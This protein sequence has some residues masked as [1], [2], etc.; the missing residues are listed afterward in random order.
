MRNVVRRSSHLLMVG[1]GP[2]PKHCSFAAVDCGPSTMKVVVVLI[3]F[4]V[5][6]TAASELDNFEAQHPIQGMQ[7][8]NNH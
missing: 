6:F 1:N 4:Y 8:G 7:Q 2:G 5:A 3:G